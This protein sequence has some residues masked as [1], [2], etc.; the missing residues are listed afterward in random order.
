MVKTCS[1]C[2]IEKEY[3]EFNKDKLKKDGL[4]S[5]CKSCIKEYY[6]QHYQSNREYYKQHY[7]YNKERI[8]EHYKYNKERSKE[9]QKKYYQYNKE[10][11]REYKKEYVKQR[12]KTDTLFKLKC[13]LRKRTQKAFRNKGYSKNTQTREMLGVDWKVVKQHI[14]RQFTKG[15]NWS[16]YGEW[17]IDHIIPLA[18][19][20]TPERLKQLCHYT[21]L[22]P[23]WAKENLSKSDKIIGQQT[24]LRI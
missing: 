18:S 11:I 1:K 4:R 22:Q 2:K 23:M 7:Q 5:N 19:A 24:L 10:R 6:K 12:K 13:N 9:Y 8:K 16:N 17:H 3:S 15:M 21:N 14:E 20:K